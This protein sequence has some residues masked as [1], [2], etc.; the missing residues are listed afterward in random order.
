MSLAV[1]KKKTVKRRGLDGT[2]KKRVRS[3]FIVDLTNRT[4]FTSEDLELSK[5]GFNPETTGFEYLY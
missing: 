5:I 3:K 4:L 2:L 1:V